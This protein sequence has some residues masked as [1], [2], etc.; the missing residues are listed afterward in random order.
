MAVYDVNAAIEK[1]DLLGSFRQGQV[2]GQQMTAANKERQDNEA[3]RGLAPQIIAGDPEAFAQGAVISPDAAN[4]YQSAGD[5]QLK[6]LKGAIDFIDSAKDTAMK[7]AYYQQVRPYLARFGQEPPATFAEAAPKMEEARARISMIGQE[8]GKVFAQKIG[9]DG[10]IYNTMADGRMVNTGV[11]AD[12]QMW[13][14]DQPGIAPGLVTKEGTIM[15]LAEGA[16]PTAQPGAVPMQSQSDE[17]LYALA[18]Q[19]TQAGMPQP[20][21]EAW[22]TQ[23][24][25]APRAA[26]TGGGGGGM[27]AMPAPAAEAPAAPAQRPWTAN[28]PSPYGNAMPTGAAAA[29]P[30]IS[31]AEQQ[32]LALAQ[33]ANARA[34]QAGERADRVFETSQ[35]R[36]GIPAGYEPDGQGGVRPM[37]GGPADPAV[38]AQTAAAKGGGSEKTRKEIATK[39]VQVQAA[40]RRI[41]RISQAVE[42]IANN[43]I[44]DGGPVDAKALQYTPEGQELIS[45]T[46][47]LMPVLTALTRVPGVGAQSDLETRL[48]NLQMPSLEFPPEVNRRTLIELNLFMRDLGNAYSSLATGRV[49]IPAEQG[50]AVAPSAGPQPGAVQDGY[51]F[52]GGNP[53]D[54]N[55]WERI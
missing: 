7:E 6:R 5:A 49:P 29:R 27:G 10:F 45:A 53:A 41:Q 34:A 14:R 31:P 50:N 15:P 9:Q 1:P 52:R 18:T 30:A 39:S 43:P 36:A 28:T 13:L 55:S 33:E 44:M 46:A 25:A 8:T 21:V 2:F 37:R 12:R 17:Q 38:I 4:K 23:Q 40:Q 24:L 19:M 51:R 32:R 47:G 26:E 11:K 22:L 54:P 16:P 20:Q 3:L 42:N 48:A 35:A